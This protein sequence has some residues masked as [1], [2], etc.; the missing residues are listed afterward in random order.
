MLHA[1]VCTTESRSWNISQPTP[2]TENIKDSSASS[3][4]YQVTGTEAGACPAHALKWKGKQAE[5]GKTEW[6]GEKIAICLVAAAVEILVWCY[7]SWTGSVL[8]LHSP[9]VVTLNFYSLPLPSA[10]LLP[11]HSGERLPLCFS[12]N[13]NPNP[14]AGSGQDRVNYLPSSWYRAMCSPYSVWEQCW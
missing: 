8:H 4:F 1:K 6:E 2:L 12:P 14:C 3:L 13:P 9:P 10:A 11:P 7:S 5:W